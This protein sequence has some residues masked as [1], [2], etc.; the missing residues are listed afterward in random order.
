MNE[1]FEN[2]GTY[3]SFSTTYTI[4]FIFTDS[5]RGAP[6]NFGEQVEA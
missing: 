5:S 1:I 4:S 3:S 2:F 6:P